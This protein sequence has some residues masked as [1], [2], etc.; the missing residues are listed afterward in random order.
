MLNKCYCL[1]NRATRLLLIISLLA[2]VLLMSN[3]ATSAGAAE[4]TRS[5]TSEERYETLPFSP[6]CLIIPMDEKQDDRL[7]A[8]GML[9]ALLR[10]DT[11]C[12]RLIGP[13]AV[14]V[15]TEQVP[16]GSNYSGGPMVLLEFNITLMDEIRA[17]FPEVTVHEVSETFVWHMVY[18]IEE[19][20]KILLVYR[21]GS[22]YQ[23]SLSAALLKDMHI[24]FTIKQ[25]WHIDPSVDFMDNDLIVIEDPG[26]NGAMERWLINGIRS[27]VASG[28]NFVFIG[29]AIKDLP[30]I[31]PFSVSLQEVND[32]IKFQATFDNVGES[33]SQYHGSTLLN[34][35]T[36]DWVATTPTFPEMTPML[37][38]EGFDAQVLF[39]SYFRYG[40]GSVEIFSFDP[41]E[42][43][44]EM[45]EMASIFLGNRFVQAPPAPLKPPLPM[46]PSAMPVPAPTIPPPPPPPPPPSMDPPTNQIA[47]VLSSTSVS[48]AWT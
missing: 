20:T 45:R 16:E 37:Y 14:F 27:S 23:E 44:G 34:V 42:Q 2:I 1:N 5:I 24:P 8:F 43:V 41:E 6:G 46:A 40:D 28:R 29:K 19:P 38:A 4:Q 39:A 15:H 33:P 48:L 9:H 36:S 47:T 31:F 7:L 13:P 25:I 10:N 22:D 12:Y 17:G 11:I 35:T 21:E 30:K 18:K 3:L 32:D 26:A